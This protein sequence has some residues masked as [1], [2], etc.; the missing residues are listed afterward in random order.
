[1][2]KLVNSFVIF[3]IG[4]IA[5]YMTKPIIFFDGDHV[6]P[7]IFTGKKINSVIT[8]HTFVIFLAIISHALAS[9]L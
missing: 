6:R 1:M 5:I 9:K 8:L 2:S 4:F 3:C 7:F